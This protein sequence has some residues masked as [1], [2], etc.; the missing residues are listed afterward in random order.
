M[1]GPTWCEPCRRY[2]SLG[3]R[4]CVDRARSRA[5]ERIGGLFVLA[6]VI[7]G[8]FTAPAAHAATTF[9]LVLETW[10]TT[11]HGLPD[12]NYLEVIR[13]PGFADA[14]TCRRFGDATLKAYEAREGKHFTRH[15]LGWQC[16]ASQ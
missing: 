14:D 12:T 7:A 16:E 4:Q 3:C 5:A 6:F 9:T 10:P 2:R 11:G 13:V 8:L 1:T 15:M